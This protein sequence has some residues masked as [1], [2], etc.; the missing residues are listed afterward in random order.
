VIHVPAALPRGQR[1]CH[2]LSRR[3]GRV[4]CRSSLGELAGGVEKSVVMLRIE[5]QIL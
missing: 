1:G 2:L 5:P 3:P 4:A